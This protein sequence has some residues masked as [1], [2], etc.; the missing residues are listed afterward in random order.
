MNRKQRQLLLVASACLGGMLLFVQQSPGV[1]RFTEHA[2]QA[3]EAGRS[4]AFA[5]PFK[6]LTR[7]V[8]REDAGDT[9]SQALAYLRAEAEKR[10]VPAVNAKIDPVWKRCRVTTGSRSISIG[11]WPQP[12]R[13]R[14]DSRCR[15][16]FGRCRRRSGSINWDRIRFIKATRISGWSV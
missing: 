14:F 11:H 10:N 6:A 1:E 16:F 8:W 15:S 2:R 12:K 13:N 5:D 3:G 9:R 7:Q 4:F